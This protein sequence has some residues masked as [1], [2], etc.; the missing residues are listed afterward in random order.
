VAVNIENSIQN[1]IGFVYF[2]SSSSCTILRSYFYPTDP[3]ITM[4]SSRKHIILCTNRLRILSQIVQTEGQN[5]LTV[6]STTE[7]GRRTR[8]RCDFE[9]K[10]TS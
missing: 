6:R 1:F 10:R 2:T 5:Q 8:G 3:E 9:K 7:C 4:I